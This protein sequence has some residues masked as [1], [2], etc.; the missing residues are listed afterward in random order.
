MRSLH[1]YEE[2]DKRVAKYTQRG[3]GNPKALHKD[4]AKLLLNQKRYRDW[5]IEIDESRG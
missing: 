1:G 5:M 4:E 2:E 3:Q